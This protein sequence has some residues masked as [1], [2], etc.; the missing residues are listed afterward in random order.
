MLEKNTK[1]INKL[2]KP[3][4]GKWGFLHVLKLLSQISLCILYSAQ[5]NKGQHFPLQ[6]Y[7]LV[8]KKNHLYE[9]SV[10]SESFFPD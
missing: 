7:F 6:R 5:A 9:N 3:C 1:K 10:W 8:E 2:N 4:C